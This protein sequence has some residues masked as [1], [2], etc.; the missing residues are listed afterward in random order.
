MTKGEPRSGNMACKSWLAMTAS[1]RKRY[2]TTFVPWFA[3][4]VLGATAHV[5][6]LVHELRDHGQ[7]EPTAKVEIELRGAPSKAAPAW[8]Q[9]PRRQRGKEFARPGRLERQVDALSPRDPHRA[10]VQ[11]RALAVQRRVA[12][13]AEQLGVA[14]QRARA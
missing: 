13:Q 14:R 12:Q 11:P 8:E 5:G 4:I 2:K 3:A 7:P 9:A 6:W 1:S 10:V